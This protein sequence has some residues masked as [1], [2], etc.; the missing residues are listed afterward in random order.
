MAT[1]LAAVFLATGLVA[2]LGDAFFTGFFATTFLAAAFLAAAFLDFTADLAFDA[3]FLGAAFAAFFFGAD[4]AFLGA[5]FAFLGA[6]F[7]AGFEALP[8]LEVRVAIAYLFCLNQK[9]GVKIMDLI[10]K[11]SSNEKIYIRFTTVMSTTAFRFIFFYTFA[12]VQA[13]NI[14][15]IKF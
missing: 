15:Q 8:F 5:A 1:G 9:F 11:C 4:F 14:G 7:E 10:I 3:D 13:L 12:S 6:A 2:F